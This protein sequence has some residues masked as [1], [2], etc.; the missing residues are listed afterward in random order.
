[1]G[2]PGVPENLKE[3][4]LCLNT[5]SAP[6]RLLLNII[7][8]MTSYDYLPS[9]GLCSHLCLSMF[10]S[11]DGLRSNLLEGEHSEAA[12]CNLWSTSGPVL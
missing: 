1:M 10:E 3:V 5:Y 6:I 8:V 11:S 12:E 9:V 4:A 2:K 7:M